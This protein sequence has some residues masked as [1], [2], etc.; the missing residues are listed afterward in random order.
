MIEPPLF[1]FLVLEQEW[2][3]VSRKNS[4]SLKR[5]ELQL[6]G[7]N[8]GHWHAE[9]VSHPRADE[10]ILTRGQMPALN[11]DQLQTKSYWLLFSQNIKLVPCKLIQKAQQPLSNHPAQP[12]WPDQKQTPGCVWWK[13]FKFS[14]SCS[15]S[16]PK[17]STTGFSPE[18]LIRH[19]RNSVVYNGETGNNLTVQ[20]LGIS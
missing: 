19:L 3:A 16:W 11:K 13:A 6:R 20:D 5:E 7:E 17:I 12:E 8:A 1:Q 10:G 4:K 18:E 14:I 15:S 9:A 2:E